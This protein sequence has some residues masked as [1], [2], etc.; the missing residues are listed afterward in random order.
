MLVF[1]SPITGQFAPLQPSSAS[2]A[3][4]TSPFGVQLLTGVTDPHFI[5]VLGQAQALGVRWVRV[6]L[7]WSTIQPRSASDWQWSNSDLLLTTLTARGFT[8]IVTI[9]QNPGWATPNANGPIG[10]DH[11]PDFSNFVSTLAERYP[12]VQYWEFYNEP[13]NWASSGNG[14]GG[15]G[16]QYAAMLAAAYNAIHTNGAPGA[17][18]NPQYVVFG[19]IAYETAF[20]CPDRPNGQ[21]FDNKFVADVMGNANGSPL[22]DV[23]AFHFYAG[24]AA[25][26]TPANVVGKAIRLKQNFPSLAN[27]PFLVTELGKGYEYGVDPAYSHEVTASL[28]VEMFATLM[29]GVDKRY[30]VDILAG[31]WFTLE[32]TETPAG[33]QI[34]KWGLLDE[35]GNPWPLEGAAYA[36]SARELGDATY[37]G[38]LPG[39]SGVEGYNFAA[40]DGSV[41]SVLWASGEPARYSFPGYAVRWL[42]ERGAATTVT[43]N[44]A[45]DGDSRRGWIGIEITPTPVFVETN[46][47]IPVPLIQGVNPLLRRTQLALFAVICPLFHLPCNL[48]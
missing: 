41:H 47:R 38:A 36:T 33:N 40:P 31:T 22:F 25:N 17:G 2:L 4:P 14:W 32:H 16:K 19:G 8:P 28:I 5:P 18:S 43:D 27:R 9:V 1:G 45:G 37:L 7:Y 39:S 34:R 23:M 15:E 35:A 3:A 6:Y 12:D 10:P 46:I 48:N 24:F 21:C 42:D 44:G 13:D 11:L 29:A 26:Y 30:G 20:A